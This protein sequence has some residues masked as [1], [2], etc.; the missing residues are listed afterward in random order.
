VSLSSS[1]GF[2][3]FVEKENLISVLVLQESEVLWIWDVMFLMPLTEIG[4]RPI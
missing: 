4:G 2:A 3:K 1:S